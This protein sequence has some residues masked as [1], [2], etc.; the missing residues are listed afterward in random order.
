[1]GDRVYIGFS[2][3]LFEKTES[4]IN[5]APSVP[6]THKVQL[7]AHVEADHHS[8]CQ[9]RYDT[10]V[11]VLATAIICMQTKDVCFLGFVFQVVM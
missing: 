8:P 10:L 1:M 2:V 9:V 5:K 3:L 7:N 6:N 4:S 11:F